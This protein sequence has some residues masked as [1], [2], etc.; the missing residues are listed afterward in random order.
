MSDNII[1]LN[2]YLIHNELQDLV[3]NSVEETLSEFYPSNIQL[4]SVFWSAIAPSFWKFCE[5]LGLERFLV[6]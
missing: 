4:A 3:R 6:S 5:F 1:Q 2:Q